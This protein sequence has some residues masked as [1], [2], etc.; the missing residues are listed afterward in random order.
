[1]RYRSLYATLFA[2]ALAVL[3]PSCIN[4]LTEAPGQL[5]APE[6]FTAEMG[7]AMPTKT[8]L[9]D[10]KKTILWRPNDAIDVFYSG[11]FMG[12]YTNYAKEDN[13]VALFVGNAT[14]FVG[15][16]EDSGI[17]KSYWAVYP[18]LGVYYDS[19]NESDGNSITTFIPHEQT[20]VAG[21]FGEG[22][23]VTIAKSETTALQFYHVCGGIK[24]SVT[25]EGIQQVEF[26]GNNGEP[27]AG[28]V[29]V[30]MNDADRPVI[31]S[32]VESKTTITMTMPDGK[33]F[34][35]GTWYYLSCAPV[36]LTQGFTLTLRTATETGE[37]TS[38]EPISVKRAVWGTLT[39]VDDNVQYQ[40]AYNNIYGI[41]AN[42]IRY[43]TTDGQV[44]E[45]YQYAN[46]DAQLVS[47][48]YEDGQGIMI[49]D[50]PVTSIGYRLFTNQSDNNVAVR[51]KSIELPRTLKEL[52]SSTFSDC[53][54]IDEI[55]LPLTVT[56][57]GYG[58]FNRCVSL[59]S[60]NIPEG[61]TN[62]RESAFY[63]CSSLG[64]IEIPESVTSFERNAFQSCSSLGWINI[65]SGTTSIGAYAFSGC[66]N[67]GS[68]DIPGSVT[69]IGEGA[70]NGCNFY[71][72]DGPFASEDH[73]CLIFDGVLHAITK[74]F[75]APYTYTLPSGI[76]RIPQDAFSNAS[77]VH[78]IIPSGVTQIDP[79]AFR[80]SEIY[81]FTLPDTIEQIEDAFAEHAG[82]SYFY[83][84][85]ASDD[86]RLLIINNVLITAANS[87][88]NYPY[89]LASIVVPEGVTRIG[90]HAFYGFTKLSSVT[91]PSTIE[92]IGS[93]AFG[94][95][96]I[97]TINFPEGLK[98]IEAFA[99]NYFQKY[100]LSDITLPASL[101]SI[102]YFAFG[103][104]NNSITFKSTTPPQ[105]TPVFPGTNYYGLIGKNKTI[106]VPAASLEAY[107]TAEGW[108]TFA[109]QIQAIPES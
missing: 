33:F 55:Y 94:G 72:I 25:H 81:R 34:Q 6:S 15:A 88:N 67:L 54:S 7:D 74:S 62:I 30:T 106:Y 46:I 21:N 27:L 19:L 3:A 80:H 57:L 29:K 75:D 98:S 47:N 97:E 8:T 69:S 37:Y 44:A 105:L 60:V 92:S 22:S 18:C 104:I 41:A 73:R 52:G 78:L 83:G 9:A 87:Y 43:T 68:I 85:G 10:D 100:N 86:N 51:I 14:T 17:N 42:E 77:L 70:F 90:N 11:F 53:E 48:T 38:T 23:L 35:P 50:G 109:D 40:T 4:Q 5:K 71:S 76:T 107:K 45:L 28:K 16:T 59:S 32:F 103:G 20:P 108:S 93:Y 89:N 95:T 66:S 91:L 13:P 82:I 39:D 101:E 99:F 26:K 61:I 1:M 12:R 56:S 102:G 24:F 65:P 63:G 36:E 84:Y 2:A 58:V 31:D 64:G 49:F 96:I 79:Y